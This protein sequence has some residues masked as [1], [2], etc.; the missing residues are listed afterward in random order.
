MV[1]INLL[2]N[3]ESSEKKFESDKFSQTINLDNE[4]GATS[5]FQSDFS[6]IPQKSNN[7]R[8]L[9]LLAVLAIVVVAVIWQL[10]P[11]DE[12]LDAELM[13]MTSLSDPDVTATSPA[14]N[15]QMTDA[16]NLNPAAGSGG[17]EPLKTVEPQITFES[18]SPLQQQML[19]STRLG[20]FALSAISESATGSTV[21]T[22]IRYAGK[23]FLAQFIT[24]SAGET[25]DLVANMQRQLAAGNLKKESEE[26]VTSLSRGGKRVIISGL[27]SIDSAPVDLNS[28]VQDMSLSEFENWIN[29]TASTNGLEKNDYTKGRPT[30]EDGYNVTR[31]Q[32]NLKG[33]LNGALAFLEE[34]NQ[35]APSIIIDKFLLINE[36]ASA[37]TANTVNLVLV[38]KHYS[39]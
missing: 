9:I 29:Q 31:I 15:P 20:C 14:A 8:L 32:L 30:S 25:S 18:L 17:I 12:S 19:S 27:L 26:T 2:G 33:S 23:S 11:G 6:E 36:D 3:E 1:D 24:G 21:F 13:P 28:N 5:G 35:S 16:G 38:L 37:Q 4:L 39:Y 34:L 7:S 22:L 10:L